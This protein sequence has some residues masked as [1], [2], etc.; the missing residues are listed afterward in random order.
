MLLESIINKLDEAKLMKVENMSNFT[1]AKQRKTINHEYRKI[2]FMKKTFIEEND[3]ELWFS[4]LTRTLNSY[5]ASNDFDSGQNPEDVAE[6][7]VSLNRLAIAKVFKKFDEEDKDI[8]EQFQKLTECEWHV[9]RIL[10]NQ[11]E[12]KNKV[13]YVDFNK[14]RK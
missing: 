13:R 12:L 7:F 14:E 8:L 1:G 10:K 5:E 3:N 9:F 2:F 4:W 11:L 6:N